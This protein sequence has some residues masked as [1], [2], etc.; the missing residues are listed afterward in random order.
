MANDGGLPWEE[1]LGCGMIL[2][3]RQL[4]KNCQDGPQARRLFSLAAIYDG[5]THTE[6]AKIGSVGLQ[7]SATGYCG[8]THE[9]LTGCWI[10]TTNSVGIIK[11][12]V[13]A[14]LRLINSLISVGACTGSSKG[15]AMISCWRWA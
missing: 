7:L 3:L 10:P 15:C 5:A 6:A 8:S 1:R 14:I 9:A 13:L 12:N 11:S 2:T 4:A